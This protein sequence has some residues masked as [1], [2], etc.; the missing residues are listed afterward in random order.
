MIFKNQIELFAWVRDNRPWVSEISGK[1]LMPYI[2]GGYKQ[3]SCFMHVIGKGSY[4]KFKLYHK[5]LVLATPEEHEVYDHETHKAKADP[6][7]DWLFVLA[8]ELTSQYNMAN[9]YDTFNHI[10]IIKTC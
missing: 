3:S 4:P 9:H 8:D 2:S 10:P 5:N 6:K 7:Y 1:S